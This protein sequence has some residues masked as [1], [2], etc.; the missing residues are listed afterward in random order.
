MEDARLGAKKSS[1]KLLVGY[2]VI[3]PLCYLLGMAVAIIV[4]MYLLDWTISF[5]TKIFIVTG[6]IMWFMSYVIHFDIFR[7]AI[8]LRQNRT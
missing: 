4:L 2:F 3:Y 8:S 7:L 1:T 6:G 5:S